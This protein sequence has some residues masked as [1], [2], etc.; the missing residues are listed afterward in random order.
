M[1]TLPHKTL[2][3]SLCFVIG[4][5]TPLAAS[6][7]EQ[8]MLDEAGIPWSVS[9]K[10]TTSRA[11]LSERL[12]E[13]MKLHP[14]RFD[15]K[16]LASSNHSRVVRDEFSYSIVPSNDL[17]GSSSNTLKL[18]LK[19]HSRLTLEKSPVITT[20]ESPTRRQVLNPVDFEEMLNTLEGEVLRLEKKEKKLRGAKR[21]LYDDLLKNQNLLYTLRSGSDTRTP[22]E[23]LTYVEAQNQSAHIAEEQEKYRIQ[24]NKI[25]TSLKKAQERARA[26]KASLYNASD[27]S[28]YVVSLLNSRLNRIIQKRSGP[29]SILKVLTPQASPIIRRDTS[30]SRRVSFSD[31]LFYSPIVSNESHHNK[32]N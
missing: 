31:Q 26:E 17:K 24:Y 32:A 12:R 19:L 11:Y 30:K 8:K 14:E 25:C 28:P 6:H 3:P 7:F 21:S 20:P 5:F 18:K 4:S 23:E 27:G 16:P 22:E 1:I 15:P 29:P 2:L 9:Q 13:Q 10:K